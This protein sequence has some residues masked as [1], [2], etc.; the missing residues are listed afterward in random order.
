MK[1]IMKNIMKKTKT[2]KRGTFRFLDF[3]NRCGEKKVSWP[4]KKTCRKNRLF[5][6]EIDN[7][8]KSARAEKLIES[9]FARGKK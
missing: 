6:Y 3:Y 4:E 8:C 2:E 5:C 7:N 1:N 9:E